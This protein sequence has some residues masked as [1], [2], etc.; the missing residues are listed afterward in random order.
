MRDLKAIGAHNVTAGR[1]SGLTGRQRFE[2]VRS[3]YPRRAE[4]G[5]FPMS[6]EIVF[7]LGWRVAP[8]DQTVVRFQPGRG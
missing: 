8:R 2:A 4:D 6:W 3:A 1:P 7:G 5:R